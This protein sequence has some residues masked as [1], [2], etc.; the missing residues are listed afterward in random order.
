MITPQAISTELNNII[1]RLVE[2]G[3]AGDQRL[4]FVRPLASGCSEVTFDMADHTTVALK[5]NKSYS[6]IYENLTNNRAYVAKLP[7][8]ALCLVRYFFNANGLAQHSIGFFPSPNLEEFQNNPDIY[9]TD[10]LYAD[11]L[12]K[13]IVPFPIRFDF[14]IDAAEEVSHP[15]SHQTLGQYKNCRIPVSAALTPTNFFQFILRN[16]YNTAYEEF[17]STLPVSSLRFPETITASERNVIHVQLPCRSVT[18]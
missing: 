7:D 16:F 3:L 15:I 13:N 2:T 10:T 6:E 1:R 5:S 12:A 18:Y 17:G 14:D 8:G 11:V 4:S 9:T